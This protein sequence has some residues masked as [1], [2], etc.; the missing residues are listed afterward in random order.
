[1]SFVFSRNLALMRRFLIQ[2]ARAT[3]SMSTLEIDLDASDMKPDPS[4]QA[5]SPNSSSAQHANGGTNSNSTTTTTTTTT[6]GGATN[7]S[8]SFSVP[9]W[10]SQASNGDD[11]PADDDDD[12]VDMKPNTSG[13]SKTWAV[14]DSLTKHFNIRYSGPSG[15]SGT[16]KQCGTLIRC[17]HRVTT[18]F[19][20]HIRKVFFLFGSNNIA[21]RRASRVMSHF[22][23]RK[24]P[25]NLIS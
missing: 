24:W 7:V 10:S 22:L 25:L 8:I 23:L 5:P 21:C 14:P 11:A 15:F 19:L 18:P 20:M 2:P 16:C 3:S 9:A 1:M 4:E 17:A 6:G 13:S 12:D